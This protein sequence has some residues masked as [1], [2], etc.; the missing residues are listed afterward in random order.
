MRL[1]LINPSNPL[2]SIVNLKESCWNRYRVWKP[3]GLMVLAGKTLPEWEITIVDENLGVPNYQA[4]P[5]P[6]LVGITAFTS[7]APR[8][9]EVAAYFRNMG[10]PVVMGGIHATMCL[11]EA[12]ERVDSVVTGEADSI[13][14]QVLKDARHGNLKRR[15]DGGLAE[16]SDIPL[17]R[18]DLLTGRYA[19]GAIQ[20]TRGCPL[21]CN[22]CSV[23]AFNGVRYRQRPIPDV[24]R[25]FQSIRDKRVLVVD[26]N[27]IGTRP[28]H[29]SRAKDLFRAM[30][31]ANLQK[32]WV[33]QVTINFADDDELL[34]LAA[35]AGC[36]G[37]FIGFESPDPEGLVELGKRFNLRKGQDFRASVR[38]IQ[39]H[40]ILV[41]GSFIIG[42]DAHKPGIGK[43]VAEAASQYGVDNLNVLFLTPLPGTR[44][45]KQMKT[46]DRIALDSF[47]EHWKYYTLTFPVAK[48]KHFSLDVI[49][50]EMLS[51]DRDFYSMSRIM[52]RVWGN[53]WQGRQPLI[54]LIG[55]LSY[56]S[57][58][59]LNCK[60]YA[61][62][63]RN[64]GDR[65]NCIKES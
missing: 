6:D 3:L 62:F 17:A 63:K 7:Q 42:L 56:R 16:I 25:E 59:R 12:M 33:A 65:H 28:E 45:W 8:A 26:D 38:R 51:C 30:A 35:K 61:D 11:D 55:N 23:T 49:I 22:F 29:I 53:L 52:R 10:I 46:E 5:R 40:N 24:L 60:A 43:R 13:W 32:E 57:N 27:L 41:V 48:Y 58:F 1:Y 15:Y 19:F 21:N 36:R 37:V 44:L 64:W 4:M 14:Q 31:Q 9:Y 54:T 34:A 50:E 47:P 18:H 20:T 2:V 39:R